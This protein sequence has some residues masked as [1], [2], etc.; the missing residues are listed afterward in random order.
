MQEF[1]KQ[2]AEWLKSWQE[3]QETLS[4]Q[5]AGCSK[6]W[7]ENMY[8]NQN[9]PNFFEGWFKPQESLAEQFKE[10]SSNLEKMIS[11]FDKVPA[12]FMKLLNFASFEECYK[13]YLSYLKSTGDVTP[14]GNLI[15]G[16]QEVTNFFRSF[17]EK[18]NPFFTTFS[19]GNF[20]D[21][22]TRVFGMLQGVWGQ[23][24][25][26]YTDIVSGYQD[27]IS[28]LFESTTAQG[29]EKLAEGFEKWAKEMEKY[30]LA[31]KVGITREMAQEISQALA[32]SQEYIHAYSRMARLIEATSRKA[33]VRFQAKLSKLALENQVVTKFTDFC[34]LWSVENEAVFLEVLGSEE[35]AK[36]QGDFVNAGHRLKI[37]W[38]KLAERVLEPTP[39][40]LKRDLDL[41]IAEIQQM[42]REMKKFQRELKEK[43]KEAQVAREAQAVAEEGAKKA[44]IAQEAAEAVAK[45]EATKLKAAEA[46]A[47]E[48]A[49]KLK[50]AEAAAKEEAT[51]L[52]AAEAAAKEEAN[53]LK[54]AEA[55]AKEEAKKMLAGNKPVKAATETTN[56]IKSKNA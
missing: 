3:N 44:K 50:A 47:K 19:D 42:K 34:A 48:E 33:G 15:D 51:R 11:Q 32:I 29:V 38:N 49:T 14:P 36:L 17:L 6:E 27:L 40:A 21:G 23:S 1:F 55:A 46:A 20:G 31:P 22:M 28:Q 4:K 39:I 26:C 53:R 18:N 30:L 25:N 56:K 7:M 2:Q 52:K 5:Y 10:F 12:E 16:W 13:N 45:E 8:G 43:G 9:K 54:A 41:A 24:G 35:F 37:Q